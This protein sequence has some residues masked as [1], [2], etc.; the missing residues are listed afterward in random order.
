MT[1]IKNVSQHFRE[2][3]ADYN[4]AKPSRFRR[5]RTGV[6]SSGSGADYHIRNYTDFIGLLEQARDLERNDPLANRIVDSA[7]TNTVQGGFNVDPQTGDDTVDQLLW[8][9]WQDWASNPDECDIAGELTFSDMEATILRRMIIDG[10]IFALPLQDGQ[11]QLIEAHRCGS[12]AKTKDNVVHGVML[13]AL[14][15]ERLEYWFTSDEIDPTRSLSKASELIKYAARDSEGNKQVLHI[16]KPNRITQTRG[17]TAF[18]QVFD[19]VAMLDDINFAKLVQQ[20]VASCF[21]IIRERSQ[22]FGGADGSS[23]YGQQT[24]ETQPGG[25]SRT[26][27]GI[28]PGM[29]ILGDVGET[30]KGFSANIPNSEYFQQVQMVVR[31]IASNIGCPPE[32]ALFDTTQTTF[33]GYRGAVDE[34]RRNFRNNQ[35]LLI[36]RFHSPVYRWKVRQ[37]ITTDKEV[38][39]AAAILGD[40]IYRHKW[41]APNWA[42]ID[43]SKDANADALRLE[44]G[45]ISP[46]R[47]AAERGCDYE[48]LADEIIQDNAYK[49]EHAAEKAKELNDE[50][51]LNLTWRDILNPDNPQANGVPQTPPPQ[52]AEQPQQ[53][54]VEPSE[55]EQPDE[56]DD[57]EDDPNGE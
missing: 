18:A 19:Y 35:R 28:A 23:G 43:A 37:W 41:N 53:S 1:D 33:H 16:Y 34:A 9:K 13:D 27:S 10:D 25:Y 57:G 30:I 11:L 4:A 24:S 47:W 32:I 48:E 21:A 46:R 22:Y 5:K 40:K 39:A 14:T 6:S 8:Q 42:Y 2:L 55:P 31:M 20:Q 49:I 50:Y 17:I 38:R 56:S 12:P 52:P 29:E 51:G 54:A 15:R 36:D 7:V 44:K 26:V 45:L 3:K